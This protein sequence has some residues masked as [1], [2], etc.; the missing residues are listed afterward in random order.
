[1]S[2]CRCGKPE[3][4]EPRRLSGSSKL[5]AVIAAAGLVLMPKCP[6]CVMA[7]VA[8]LTGVSISFAS[9]AVLRWT[10]LAVLAVVLLALAVIYGAR[11]LRQL[12]V[13]FS[14]RI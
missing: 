7:W 2:G 4:V 9:A 14:R 10:L 6:A 3:Q 11:Q 5:S 8:M 1:M 13:R 12:P